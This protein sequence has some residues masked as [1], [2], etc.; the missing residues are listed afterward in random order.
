M[1]CRDSWIP[2][3]IRYTA[4]C[5]I[6]QCIF[7]FAIM[8]LLQKCLLKSLFHTG[9]HYWSI[10][11]PQSQHLS[12]I[13]IFGACGR[14][15]EREIAS[16]VTGVCLTNVS[17]SIWL[18]CA[19][20]SLY[21]IK[22]PR[23]VFNSNMPHPTAVCFDGTLTLTSACKHVVGVEVLNCELSPIY[24]S[25]S[26]LCRNLRRTWLA[27]LQSAGVRGRSVNWG[28]SWHSSRF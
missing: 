8:Q 14:E 4:K 2:A 16:L 21:D 9:V 17:F 7:T 20:R 13:L 25:V 15:R 10:C 18:E 28:L 22:A 6:I 24:T 23:F 12:I 11:L 3:D 27:P 26:N 19:D 5:L 1:T